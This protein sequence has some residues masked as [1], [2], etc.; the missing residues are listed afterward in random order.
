MGPFLLGIVG[1][2]LVG[3]ELLMWFG[4][5][6]DSEREMILR[7]TQLLITTNSVV[8]PISLFEEVAESTAQLV[9]VSIGISPKWL[10][11]LRGGARYSNDEAK[12]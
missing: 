11:P 6:R 1:A 2:A 7:P 3:N 9:C 5:V 12:K 4:A 10:L 8:N